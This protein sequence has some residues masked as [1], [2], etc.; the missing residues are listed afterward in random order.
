MLLQITYPMTFE[1]SGSEATS[2]PKCSDTAV[3]LVMF[4]T[5]SSN[6]V[7]FSQSPF[8]PDLEVFPLPLAEFYFFQA[9][10]NQTDLS[11]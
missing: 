9:R 11:L 8:A 1:W 6:T 5:I 7:G 2:E 4:A 10:M 3:Y